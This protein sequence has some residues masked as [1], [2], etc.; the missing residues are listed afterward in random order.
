MI[1]SA[2]EYNLSISISSNFQLEPFLE[3]YGMT[4]HN[5]AFFIITINKEFHREMKLAR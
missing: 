1:C 3:L 5:M 2:I 4:L